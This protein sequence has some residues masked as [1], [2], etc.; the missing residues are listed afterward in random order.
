MRSNDSETLKQYLEVRKRIVDEALE[1]YVPGADAYPPSLC[2]AA[3]YS[4]FAGGKRLRP[5]LCMA[6]A[7]AVG[8][9][10]DAVLPVACAL[11]MI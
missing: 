2:N 4:I 8:G 7:E 5:I 9:D 10:S 1:R 11:E 3:R 6:A